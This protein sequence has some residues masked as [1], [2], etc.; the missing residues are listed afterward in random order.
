MLRGTLT[1]WLTLLALYQTLYAANIFYPATLMAVKLSIL[2]LY[3]RIRTSNSGCLHISPFS[4]L[5]SCR[6]HLCSPELL[7]TRPN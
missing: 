2:I 6:E 4:C 7:P 5:R 3:L 1:D